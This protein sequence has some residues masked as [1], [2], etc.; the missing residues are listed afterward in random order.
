MTTDIQAAFR[1]YGTETDKQ[2]RIRDFY[3]EQHTQ[4]TY[5]FVKRMER[6]Y[7][8]LPD[9]G[10]ETRPP[11]LQM[12][13]WDS[14]VFL[15]QLVDNSDPDT[16]SSQPGSVGGEKEFAEVASASGTLASETASPIQRLPT[17]DNINAQGQGS[18]LA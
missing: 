16:E 12:S 10:D 1:E 14:L 3:A 9:L 8:E 5:D 11:P 13:A 15:D 17:A 18:L 2:K 7:A 6:K 4:M